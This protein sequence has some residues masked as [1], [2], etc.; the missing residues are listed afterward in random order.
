VNHPSGRLILAHP[1]FHRLE[2]RR[3]VQLPDEP[4]HRAGTV[5]DTLA[6]SLLSS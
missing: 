3:V 1:Q 6:L 4:V 5:P 2:N